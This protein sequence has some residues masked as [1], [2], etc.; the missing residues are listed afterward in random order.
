MT[1]GDDSVD[2][3][4]TG[5]GSYERVHVGLTKREHFAAMALQGLLSD[6]GSY[7]PDQQNVGTACLILWVYLLY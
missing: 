4:T 1:D 2:S 6:K 3:I 7:F 5:Q